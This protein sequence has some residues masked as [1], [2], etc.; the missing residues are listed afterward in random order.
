MAVNK[1]NRNYTMDKIGLNTGLIISLKNV[2]FMST[3]KIREAVSI[4]STTWYEIMNA[5]ENITIQKLLAIANGL[6]IPV[7]RFFSLGKNNEIGRRDDYIVDNYQPCYYNAER[8]KSVVSSR[9]DITWQKAAKAT[10][11]S[12]YN[13][14]K[15]LLAETR[16]PVA[17]LLTVCE[18]FELDPF[19]VIIDP[20]PLRSDQK[21]KENTITTSGEYEKKQANLAAIQREISSFKALLEETKRDIAELG[22]KF[23]AVEGDIDVKSIAWRARRAAFEAAKIAKEAQKCLKEAK[24]QAVNGE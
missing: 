18:A 11:I 24:Q 16:L 23:D 15:S 19:D 7:R 21:K 4:S 13:L 8:L 9:P 5:P 10:G 12:Y 1:R 3:P 6:H 2:L 22:K 20:N 14:Q 17:R